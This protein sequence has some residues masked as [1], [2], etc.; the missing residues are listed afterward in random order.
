MFFQS[1]VPKRLRGRLGVRQL[2]VCLAAALASVPA[3]AFTLTIPS[4]AFVVTP[5]FS[6][7]GF[8]S[9]TIEVDAPLLP[10]V[11]TE[12]DI[13]SVVYRV[14]GTLEPGTQSGFPAFDLQRTITGADFSLQGSS[15][16]FEIAANAVLSDGLQ[17]AELVG[18]GVVFRFNGRE[19]DNRRFHPALLE[20]SSNGTGTIQNSNNI[21]TVG[22]PAVEVD[23]GEEYITNL[24]FDTGNLTIVP[25]PAGLGGSGSALSPLELAL[26]I[27]AG[28]W[29]CRRRGLLA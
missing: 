2:A 4:S 11:Y 1:F 25:R 16:Q 28:L 9:I 22:P 21:H 12:A 29:Q 13:S 14:T 5:V 26:L 8:F 15:L 10:G 3:A 7:V 23:F 27:L 6:N 20:L 18:N 17:V 24:T 19:I